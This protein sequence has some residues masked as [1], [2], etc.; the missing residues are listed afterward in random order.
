MHTAREPLALALV[1]H[2][3][4]SRR[5]G[6]DSDS[7]D[8][9]KEPRL[10]LVTCDLRFCHEH[11]VSL[12]CAHNGFTKRDLRRGVGQARRW[13]QNSARRLR[14]CFAEKPTSTHPFLSS[15]DAKKVVLESLQICSQ[16]L[17]QPARTCTKA[18]GSNNCSNA[19]TSNRESCVWRT[20][21]SCR[22]NSS[23][24]HQHGIDAELAHRL[25]SLHRPAIH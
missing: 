18:P 4:C 17:R 3:K 1:H 15:T 23:T 5:H 8:L 2:D 16:L 24:Q 19:S 11:L 20:K 14:H 12:N 10:G 21:P 22:C 7:K 25:I 6:R 13:T 9:P